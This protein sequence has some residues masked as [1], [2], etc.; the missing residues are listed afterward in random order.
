MSLD[1]PFGVLY[2]VGLSEEQSELAVPSLRPA[3]VHRIARLAVADQTPWGHAQAWQGL[4][5]GEA[6]LAVPG[7]PLWGILQAMQSCSGVTLDGKSGPN[8]HSFT[9]PGGAGGL[10]L[11]GVTHN[12]F[13]S[14]GKARG[15]G[16]DQC[17]PLFRMTRVSISDS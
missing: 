17:W 10:T 1:K 5:Q 11:V 9:F 12:S 3:V 2:G 4:A 16:A 15:K 8:H 13:P 14:S 6:S 7:T